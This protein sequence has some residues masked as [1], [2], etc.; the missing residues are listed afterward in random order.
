MITMNSKKT[1][2]I[3]LFLSLSAVF[4]NNCNGKLPGGDARKN[5][6]DPAKRVEQN[7]KEGRGFKLNDQFKKVVVFS[8]LRTLM[9]FGELR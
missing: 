6:A 4:L 7:L 3:L 8:I 1:I 5:P 9:N 2:K